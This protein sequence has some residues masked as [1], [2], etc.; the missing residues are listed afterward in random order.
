MNF[1]IDVNTALCLDKNDWPGV[2]RV[3][4]KVKG[5]MELVFGKAQDVILFDGAPADGEYSEG[6]IFAG[7]IGKSAIIDDLE[8]KGIIDLSGI[9]GKREVYLFTTAEIGGV[10]VLVIAGSD[11]RGTIYGLFHISELMKVSPWVWFAD[12]LP[13]KM[14]SLQITDK[15]N[16]VSREPSVRFRGFFINDEW[17]SF[18]TWSRDNFGGFN[19]SVYDHVF[20]LLLRMHGNYLWPAMWS[21]C[22]SEDGPGIANAELADEY[23]VVMGTSHHEPCMRHGEE[24]SHVKGPDSVYGNDWNFNR[25]REGL[26]NFW[27]DGL[28]RNAPFEN[29]VTVGMRGEADSEMLGRECTTLDNINYLKDV[30]TTQNGL[31]EEVYGDRVSEIDKVFAVY[32]E[33]EKFYYGDEENEGLRCWEGL[34]GTIILLADDNHGYM[35]LLPP[36]EDRGHKGGFGMYYHLDY[37]G[38]PVSYEWVNS[39][40]ISRIAEQM[41]QA[42]D[43]GVRDLW[44]VNVGDLK[45]VEFPLNYFMDLAYD[46]DKWSSDYSSYTEAWATAQFGKEGA[47]AVSEA[48]NLLED[49][50]RINSAKR[51]E[52]IGPFTFNPVYYDEGRKML[53]KAGRVIA[54]ADAALERYKGSDL[55][56]AFFQ[57]VY[58][59]A[60]ASMNVLTMQ[61]YSGLDITLAQRGC[62]SANYYAEGIR[63]CL[64]LDEEL[65]N[66]YNEL[67]DGKWRGMMLSEHIG[68]IH[69]NEEEHRI[70]AR[71]YVEPYHKSRVCVS[72]VGLPGYTMGGDWTKRELLMTDL[73]IPGAEGRISI[74]NCCSDEA[75][76][77]AETDAEWIVLSGKEGR[78][79]GAAD[80]AALSDKGPDTSVG[81]ITVSADRELLHKACVAA[82]KSNITGIVKITSGTAKIASGPARVF[83]KVCARDFSEEEL[84]A[85]FYVPFLPDD[86]RYPEKEIPLECAVEAAD[87][88][89]LSGG[90]ES[91]FKV[92]TSYEKFHSGIRAV[93]ADACGDPSDM[94]CASYRVFI[95]EEGE[96]ELTVIAAPGGPIQRDTNA[97]FGVS[98]NDGDVSILKM[99]SDDYRAGENSCGDWCKAV[100]DHERSSSLTFTGKKGENVIRICGCEPGSVLLRLVIR[101]AKGSRPKTYF[102]PGPDYIME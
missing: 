61:L 47:Q 6:R 75:V 33:V 54:S 88:E 81:Y 77:T 2:I 96:Y 14:D 76:W 21:S 91:D 37:H 82:G 58:F 55:Y 19:T 57:L 27:R 32:K 42:W 7:C 66:A 79:P 11:K 51:P 52:A 72:V 4:G 63:Q 64:K 50:T 15:D 53:A 43:C 102:G 56:D 98:I 30:I 31:M 13:A 95:P 93:P 10:T 101:Q 5:D 1:T 24:F 18:G 46:Y 26:I 89:K 67:G 65:C 45:P 40:H 36:K 69:W 28:K 78:I 59:P 49:Y 100:L 3:A 84:K 71:S 25:N 73:L 83:V 99:V 62:P 94:P 90:K 34:D 85:S 41:G 8:K 17:P 12:V 16:T 9:R 92:F 97:S 86:I 74:E 22:F 29:V 70:P 38:G 80:E 44:I 68:F 23:G 48:V 20:E 35:R 60:K 87:F 39:T